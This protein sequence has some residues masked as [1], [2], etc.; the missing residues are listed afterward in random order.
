[1]SEKTKTHR[2]L[3]SQ[4]LLLKAM[5]E[6]RDDDFVRR[7]WTAPYTIRAI[8]GIAIPNMSLANV[9]DA[10]TSLAADRGIELPDEKGGKSNG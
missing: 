9:K 4:A 8:A 2:D 5:F 10:L 1:M 3:S 7:A 6:T